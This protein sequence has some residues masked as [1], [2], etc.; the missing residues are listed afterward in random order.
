M[1]DATKREELAAMATGGTAGADAYRTGQQRVVSDQQAAIDAALSA[2]SGRHASS[3][4][5]AALD[6]IIRPTGTA[7]A[8]RLAE[9]GARFSASQGALA[10]NLSNFKSAAAGV[11]KLAYDDALARAQEKVAA[12][13]AADKEMS[14]LAKW[15]Q[16]AMAVTEGDILRDAAAENATDRSDFDDYMAKARAANAAGLSADPLLGLGAMLGSPGADGTPG[17]LIGQ[18]DPDGMIA[19]IES[20]QK[21]P[22]SFEEEMERQQR[23]REAKQIEARQ[24]AAAEAAAQARVTDQVGFGGNPY[25][26][27]AASQNRGGDTLG[28]YLQDLAMG[29]RL[30]PEVQRKE[31][32]LFGDSTRPWKDSLRGS[33]TARADELAEIEV[34]RSGLYDP[35]FQQE[36]YI[37]L[38][39]DPMLA[40]G[41]FRM[42]PEQQ[43]EIDRFLETGFRDDKEEDAALDAEKLGIAADAG[44]SPSSIREAANKFF[45]GDESQAY[46]ALADPDSTELLRAAVQEAIV[47]L[48]SNADPAAVMGAVRDDIMANVPDGVPVELLLMLAM[49]QLEAYADIYSPE[50]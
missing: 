14:E 41:L 39:G 19:Y 24:A 27:T 3:D 38:G 37:G 49:D 35:Y 48:Q 26:V 30:R 32:N 43:A 4:A 44:V 10:G 33:A 8:N 42:D 25:D 11:E 28:V 23:K 5:Q 45:G 50:L 16:E 9:G 17:G 20:L 6:A 22:R 34:M 40:G 46:L 2:A 36:A 13:A 1:G 29:N 47:A 18:S 7:A 12:K 15:R 21:I 31:Y